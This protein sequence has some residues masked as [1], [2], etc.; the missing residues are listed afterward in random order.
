M[1]QIIHKVRHSMWRDIIL[2][3]QDRST[4]MSTKQ[5]LQENQISEKSYYYWQRKLRNEIFE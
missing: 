3:C 1:D 4:G 2:Q 5:W